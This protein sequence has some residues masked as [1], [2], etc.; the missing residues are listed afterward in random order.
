[1]PP[2]RPPSVPAVMPA[3]ET[4]DLPELCAAVRAPSLVIWGDRDR[5][6]CENGP[7]LVAALGARERVL[8][9]VGHMPMLEAPYAF[10]AEMG[11]FLSAT[12]SA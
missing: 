1:M 12:V 9:G 5:S 8:P 2:D 10:S 4:L 11:D 6:S 7:P 3:L